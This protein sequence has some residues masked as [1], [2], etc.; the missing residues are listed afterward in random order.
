L[1]KDL[2]LLLDADGYIDKI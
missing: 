2:F 1:K